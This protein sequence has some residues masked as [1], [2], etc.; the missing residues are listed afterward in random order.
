MDKKFAII[1]IE[2]TGG[3]AKRDKITEIA[4]VLHNGSQIL[5]TWQTLINPERSIPYFITKITGIN[6]EMVHNAP[7]FY[8]IAKEIVERT[9]DAIF[10]A[11]NVRFDYGFIAEEFSQ[12]GYT[13]SKSQLCTVQMSRRA[14][15]GLKSYSLG[16]LVKHFSIPLPNHHRAMDDA[17]ATSEL[18][19]KIVQS[20]YYQKMYPILGRQNLTE[21][22]LPAHID[23]KFLDSIPN[24]PGVY[25]FLNE[26][27]QI[28]YV[29]K[30]IHLRKR[31]YDHF[32]D[33]SERA[34]RLQAAVYSIDYQYTGNELA[35]LLLES[36][37]IKTLSPLFN[38]AQ[39][40][41]Y[42]K[43]GIGLNS[44]KKGID[45]FEIIDL[46][47]NGHTEIF[48][49]YTTRDAANSSLSYYLY[50]SGICNCIRK[51]SNPEYCMEAKLEICESIRKEGSL[52]EKLIETE[53]RMKSG[54]EQDGIYVG[55][56]RNEEEA[57]V[58]LIQNLQ[59]AGMGYISKDITYERPEEILEDIQTYPS[60]PEVLG[61][62]NGYLKD[63]IDIQF[64]PVRHETF[65]NRL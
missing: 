16:N 47:K 61:I 13:Y 65:Q 32:A 48:K 42:F 53:N 27:N 51:N 43:Y 15:P 44:N 54:F 41:R 21:L 10:V 9:E 29:G 3:S 19:S 23:R 40:K 2:T 36:F 39:R 12:L 35:A 18:F 46:D 63:H 45:R 31:I 38:K 62:I 26:K 58:I 33:K 1:D 30:S 28:I 25:Y 7:K 55:P 24:A 34:A 60:N 14:F 56:G 64:T 20:T 22:K 5:D 17:L 4:I 6:N 57:F 11:H 8:E 59:F 37:E 50:E 49:M 52:E